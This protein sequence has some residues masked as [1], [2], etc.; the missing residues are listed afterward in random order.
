MN[1]FLTGFT[2]ILYLLYK[3]L[4]KKE[5]PAARVILLLD[6]YS[7]H[8]DEKELVS[9]DKKLVTRFLPPNVTALNQPKDYSAL[10]S[11]KQHYRRK[12]LNDLNQRIQKSKKPNQ[13]TLA[14]I[15][16]GNTNYA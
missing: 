15:I 14:G 7:A 16:I 11:I 10:S 5:G 1:Y 9:N 3:K 12:I 13:V 2:V 8:P 6:N 4:L